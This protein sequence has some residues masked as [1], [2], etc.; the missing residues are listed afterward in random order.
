MRN[1][2][3]LLSVLAYGISSISGKPLPEK[4]VPQENLPP[5]NLWPD[6]GM[7]KL[8]SHSGTGC[9]TGN[10]DSVF[11]NHMSR[12][13]VYDYAYDAAINY[14]HIGLLSTIDPKAGPGIDKSE[15]YKV[16]ETEWSY[17]AFYNYTGQGHVDYN[18]PLKPRLHINATLI[19]S[20]YKLADGAIATWKV[21]YIIP[22][23]KDVCSSTIR[24]LKAHRTNNSI[25][26]R[27]SIP[28]NSKVHSTHPIPPSL[29][30]IP[31]HI[32]GI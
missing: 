27:S 10:S 23:Q 5:W 32:P 12:T 16:C 19:E 28:S 13:P 9:P 6:D 22:E 11:L 2:R 18:G 31:Q 21:T 25:F 29:M 4:R 3:V 20:R 24:F 14:W 17:E 7:I 26:H 15:S 1:L 30:V 8:L